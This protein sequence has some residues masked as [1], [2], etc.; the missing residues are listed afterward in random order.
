MSPDQIAV[1][2]P[3]LLPLAREQTHDLNEAH[4]L[5]HQVVTRLVREAGAESDPLGV[6][7][8]EAMIKSAARQ[9][10]GLS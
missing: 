2:G 4:L 9:N 5:V 6:E 10:A 1:L 3:E 8:A 7:Q